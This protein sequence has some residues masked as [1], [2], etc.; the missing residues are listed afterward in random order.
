MEICNT[1]M[2]VPLLQLS[3]LVCTERVALQ[4]GALEAEL[5]HSRER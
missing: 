3:W 1:L 2:S 4:G 5:K